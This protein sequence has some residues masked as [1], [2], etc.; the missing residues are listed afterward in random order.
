MTGKEQQISRIRRYE[1]MLNEAKDVLRRAETAIEAYAKVRPKIRK[2]EKYYTGSTWKK[3]FR[4]SETGKLPADLP[5]GVLSEDG[6]D[7]LLEEDREL[8]EMIRE[9]FVNED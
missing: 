9:F 8:R 5:C 7:D 2:L 1:E 4:A 3:D 6:I